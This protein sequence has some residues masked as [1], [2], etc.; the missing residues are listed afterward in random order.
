M[1]PNVI[2]YTQRIYLNR[3]YIHSKKE[4]TRILVHHKDSNRKENINSFMPS[5]YAQSKIPNSTEYEISRV[6]NFGVAHHLLPCR[7]DHLL[8][9]LL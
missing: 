7:Q 3:G 4:W 6:T 9:P 8:S 1:I 2:L 5:N